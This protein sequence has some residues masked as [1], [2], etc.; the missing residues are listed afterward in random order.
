LTGQGQL[1]ALTPIS[2]HSYHLKVN[3]F[4]WLGSC[5]TFLIFMTD[6]S[7]EGA[8]LQWEANPDKL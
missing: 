8:A 3:K 5:F 4:G 6:W 7:P 1:T 2:F